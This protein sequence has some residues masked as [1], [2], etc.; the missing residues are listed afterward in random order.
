M[1]DTRVQKADG[2][3][4]EIRGSRRGDSKAGVAEQSQKEREEGE[5]WLE[6]PEEQ[7]ECEEDARE[8]LRRR[9]KRHGPGHGEMGWVGVKRDRMTD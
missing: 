9:A 4:A 2:S 7:V 5:I 8:E 6:D 1:A 3:D